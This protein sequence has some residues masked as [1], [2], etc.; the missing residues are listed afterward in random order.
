MIKIKMQKYT[1]LEEHN[2]LRLDKFLSTVSEFSRSRISSLIK[3]GNLIPDFPADYP[4]KTGEI[5]QLKIPEATPAIPLPE[6]MSLDILYEDNDIIVLNKSAGIVVHPGAGNYTGTLVN[7]L[8]AHCG[9]SLSGIGGV[10]RPGI[11]HRIDKETSGILVVA[12]NDAAH[13]GLAEQFEVHSIHRL[14]QAVVYGIPST[15]GT[16]RGNI[17][18]SP[19]NR[20]KMAI[21]EGRGKPAITHYKLIKPLFNGK[22]SLIECTLETGRTHQIRVHMTSLGHPLVGDKL[23]GSTPKATPEILKLFPRHALHAA[24]LGF[25]HPITK[26]KLFFKAKMPKD[27]DLLIKASDVL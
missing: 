23:Y 17:G 22:A 12:K 25:T 8:L 24:E 13:H 7:A 20:Q 5:F 21:V 6:N 19:H 10:I 15:C 18:R 1:V 4:V 14:Y 26:E 3:K 11:V 16:V 9:D 27:M 2:G